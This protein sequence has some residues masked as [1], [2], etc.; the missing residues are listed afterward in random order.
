[1]SAFVIAGLWIVT[2][3]TASGTTESANGHGTINVP[4]G[5]TGNTVKR[6]FSF[7]AQRRADGTVTGN[8]ILHNP[9]FEG[10]NGNTYQAQFD[11]SCMKVSSRTRLC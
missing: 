9:A 1:M 4:D 7:T 2:K 5:M 10:A 3:S 11:I 8:A 6:Q